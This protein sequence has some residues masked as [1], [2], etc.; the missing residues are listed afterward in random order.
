MNF[1][2]EIF[3]R[4]MQS[5]YK[6]DI[7][8]S[9]ENFHSQIVFCPHKVKPFF[10]KGSPLQYLVSHHSVRPVD[11][12][13]SVPKGSQPSS[14]RGLKGISNRWSYLEHDT[15]GGEMN[16]F[17][18]MRQKYARCISLKEYEKRKKK[19]Q[20]KQTTLCSSERKSD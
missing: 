18:K 13:C 15:E 2:P 3:K 7:R 9:K 14:Q 8:R 5:P 19:K 4:E 17:M 16:E 6:I 20:R 12:V 1:K 11:Y 10:P